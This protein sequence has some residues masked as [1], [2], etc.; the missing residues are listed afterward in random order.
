MGAPLVAHE[1]TT[2]TKLFTVGYEG[3]SLDEYCALLIEHG[4]RAIVDVRRNPIS[5]KKG[6]SKT[7]LSTGLLSSGIVYFH[8]P[9]LGIDS[10]LRKELET[11]EDYHEL[12][13]LYRKKL[14][15]KA[16]D[17]LEALFEITERFS[18]IALTCFERD[19]AHCHRHCISDYCFENK[20]ISTPAIH[21]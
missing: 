16:H 14:L 1:K 17:G 2:S 4:V 19:P 15:P 11:E 5:R 10:S 18:A 21:I 12:F 7:A 13:V 8:L 9:E 6:F 3:R 20:V